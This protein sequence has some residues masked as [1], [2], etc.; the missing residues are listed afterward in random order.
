LQ[1]RLAS[2]RSPVRFWVFAGDGFARCGGE[3]LTE[4]EYRLRYGEPHAFTL[5]LGEHAPKD[6]A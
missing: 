4:Q 2:E 3:V 6:A 5:H 1:R